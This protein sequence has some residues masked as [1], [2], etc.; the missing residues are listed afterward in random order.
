[1]LR[2]VQRL[3]PHLALSRRVLCATTQ[4]RPGPRVDAH[5]LGG[6][7]SQLSA[8]KHEDTHSKLD[9]LLLRLTEHRQQDAAWQ[10]YERL[11]ASPLLCPEP[12]SYTHLTLPT[13][14]SV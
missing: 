10:I 6:F 1:M 4:A 5:E 7:I 3:A 8:S 11:R 12:V 13:I 2:R 9:A 14:C